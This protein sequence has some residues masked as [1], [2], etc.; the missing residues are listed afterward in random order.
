MDYNSYLS[1]HLSPLRTPASSRHKKQWIAHNYRALL[2][3]REDPNI[4]E[5]GPGFGELLEYLIRDRGF[6]RVRAI[7]ISEEAVRV[8]NGLFPGSTTKIDDPVPYLDGAPAAFDFIFSLQVLE[9]VPRDGVPGFLRAVRGALAEGGSAVIEVP[10][11]ANLVAGRFYHDSD[12][13]HENGFNELSLR[14]VLAEAGFS[15]ISIV[16][17]RV[18]PCSPARVAQR[19]LVGLADGAMSA[20]YRL[21]LPSSR[22][23]TAPVIAAIAR[24]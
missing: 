24:K 15:R 18:P 12:W 10:N 14:H 22:V 20:L 4:L 5:I 11:L 19:I 1:R 9:H 23:V 8:C 16:P 7:D 6:S 2:R 17:L 13:T 21:Y 3:G